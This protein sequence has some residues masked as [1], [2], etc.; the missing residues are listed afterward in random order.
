[1]NIEII[2]KLDE[3][4]NLIKNDKEYIKMNQLEDKLKEDKDLIDDIN[5]LKNMDKYDKNY[6]DLKK[7]ILD[8]PEYKEFKS[9]EN[10]YYFFIKEINNKLN[11]LKEM[12]GCHENN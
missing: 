7:K 11:S 10:D 12:S 5:R 6:L 2:N 9:L 8:N 4:I 1:M 3:I